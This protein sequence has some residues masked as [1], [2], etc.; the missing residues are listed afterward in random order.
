VRHA[1][2]VAA[3]VVGLLMSP[4]IF[5]ALVWVIILT[6]RYF[7]WVYQAMGGQ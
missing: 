3:F 4:W 1:A 6:A 5:G 2:G 7:E